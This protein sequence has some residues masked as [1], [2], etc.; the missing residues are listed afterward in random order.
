M[1]YVYIAGPYT[2]GDTV[3]NI[4]RAVKAATRLRKLGYAPYVPHLSHVWHLIDPQ[5]IEFWYGLDIEWLEKCNAVIRLSGLSRG[6]DHEVE[7]AKSKGIPVFLSVEKF[8][9]AEKRR[10]PRG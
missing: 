8:L 2:R 7:V 5:P 10:Y 4:R 1:K 3:L 6:A 9:Q